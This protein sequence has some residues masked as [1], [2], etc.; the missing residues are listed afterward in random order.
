M[1]LRPRARSSRLPWASVKLAGLLALLLLLLGAAAA[2]VAAAARARD[3]TLGCVVA[4]DPV[5]GANKV[6]YMSPCVAECSGKQTRFTRGYCP[7]DNV[8]FSLPAVSSSPKEKLAVVTPAA[9]AKFAAEGF[10]FIGHSPLSSAPRRGKEGLLR[11]EAAASRAAATT[12]GQRGNVGD[13][14]DGIVSYN[15][16]GAGSAPHQVL[17]VDILRGDPQGNVFFKSY[18]YDPDAS[19]VY[20]YPPQFPAGSGSRQSLSSTPT[21]SAKMPQASTRPPAKAPPSA[22]KPGGAAPSAPTK[23][24]SSPPGSRPKA[25]PA[26]STPTR[27]SGRRLLTAL[28]QLPAL[29]GKVPRPRGSVVAGADVGSSSGSS[30]GGGGDRSSTDGGVLDS[31]GGGDAGGAPRSGA[32]LHRQLTVIGKDERVVCPINSYPFGAMGQLEATADDGTFMCSGALIA[33]DRLLTAAHCVWDDRKAHSFFDRLAFHPAQYKVGGRIEQPMGRVDWEHVTTFKAYVD[34]PDLPP[35]LR[36]DIAIV[37][38]VKP[39][40]VKFGWLGIRAERP[41][42]N[43]G[44]IVTM[45]LAGYPGDDPFTPTDDVFFGGCYLDS[46]RV[47]LTCADPMATHDCDSYIGQSGAPM[48]DP[49]Y[50]VRMVHTLGQLQGITTLNSGVRISKFILDQLMIEWLRPN[51]VGPADLMPAS[52]RTASRRVAGPATT[53]LGGR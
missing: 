37:K 30:R 18:S 46:C 17:K 19:N 14:F 40:G 3:C 4:V 38:L 13:S 42:C 9:M 24:S 12:P 5:C 29:L 21:E 33:P 1:E 7:G 27:P 6:S 2:P 28:S 39:I 34:D 22:T 16:P 20:S 11:K 23:V 36:F 10:H 25:S 8:R 26:P 43:A 35:G 52:P 51:L 45:S 47:N 44:E 32:A 50:Y 48:F 41:P 53:G 49:N 15:L 31:G